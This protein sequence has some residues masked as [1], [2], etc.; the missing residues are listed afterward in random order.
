MSY[1]ISKKRIKYIQLILVSPILEISLNLIYLVTLPSI[2]LL[3]NS[4]DGSNFYT[5]IDEK[6]FQRVFINIFIN[7]KLVFYQDFKNIN[8]TTAFKSYLN[9]LVFKLY[10]TE[11]RDFYAFGKVQLKRFV[12]KLNS[13][14]D[15]IQS[16]F[17]EEELET[18][19][20]TYKLLNI[21][22]C[23]YLLTSIS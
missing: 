1:L 18:S 12:T 13:C 15:N 5:G 7:A 10:D 21:S 20:T 22:K 6:Y 14:N 4:Y 8:T 17:F 3:Y 16:C 23:I 19:D 2:I 9:N 11:N